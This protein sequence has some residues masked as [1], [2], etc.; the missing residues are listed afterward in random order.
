M[1]TAYRVRNLRCIQDSSFLEVRP[2]VVFVGKNSSGKSTLL[3]V[4]PLIKQSVSEDTR[5]PILWYGRSADFGSFNEA[6]STYASSKEITFEFR[7]KMVGS[8]GQEIIVTEG[9]E[10]LF[11]QTGPA[12]RFFTTNDPTTVDISLTVCRRAEGDGTYTRAIEIRIGTDTLRL[13]A[14]ESGELDHPT[15]NG[16]PVVP[17]SP[18]NFRSLRGRFF[19][20]I[21]SRKEES[22]ENVHIKSFYPAAEG[23]FL[24]TLINHLRPFVHGNT[25][26]QTIRKYATQIAFGERSEFERHLQAISSNWKLKRDVSEF[27]TDREDLR[28]AALLRHLPRI[29]REASTQLA[30]LGTGVRY[31][32]PVRARA[33]R[34]YRFQEL[35]IDEIDPQGENVPMFLSSLSY[36]EQQSLERWMSSAIGFQVH[37]TREGGHAKLLVRESGG[38]RDINLADTGFGYSQVLPIILQLWKIERDAKEASARRRSIRQQ[39]QQLVLAVEQPE[40]HLHPHY[41]ALLADI[42]ALSVKAA[43]SASVSLSLV[44]E[45]HSEHLV[46]RLGALVEMGRLSKE[47]I[48]I[49]LIEREKTD[50]PATV[51]MATFTDQGTLSEPWPFGFFSPQLA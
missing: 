11:Y 31:L 50:T 36:F 5:E 20:N 44:V 46:N 33:S 24:E 47:D 12:G 32:E 3:R 43:Q 48:A 41:Q 1:L 10:R 18:V 9:G 38:D 7:F 40:L 2:I 8:T 29:L 39:L 14:S 23:P 45:T 37:A 30:A 26:E 49:Y 34:Y 6:V 16:R 25:K 13:V 4:F 17:S 22:P 51:H 19:P 15:F 27:G 35:A 28:V 42:F 21:V